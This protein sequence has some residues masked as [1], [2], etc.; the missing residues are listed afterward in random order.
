[1]TDPL[2]IL[3]ADDHPMIRHGLRKAI[4]EN[5]SA[6]ERDLANEVRAK[7]ILKKK[8]KE[9][10]EA[11]KRKEERKKKNEEEARKKVIHLKSYLQTFIMWMY[12]LFV[13]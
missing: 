13:C 5:D 4:E 10:E 3:I 6:K 1:M 9:E 7:Q 8:F 11:L 2:T 12:N